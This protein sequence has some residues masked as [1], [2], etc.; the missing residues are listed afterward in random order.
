LMSF[1]SQLGF[2]FGKFPFVGWSRGWYAEDTENNYANM[3]GDN[4]NNDKSNGSVAMR[5]DI[6]RTLRGAVE[7][8]KLV[9]KNR[10]DERVLNI[11]DQSS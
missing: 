4:I 9:S 7:I 1:W 6:M 8:S 11:Q 10:Y 3:V 5:E 2:V